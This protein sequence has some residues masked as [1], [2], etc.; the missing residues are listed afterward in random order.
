MVGD[1]E[2]V[3]GD[4][5]ILV[6]G[7]F[8]LVMLVKFCVGKSMI[9][10]LVRVFLIWWSNYCLCDGIVGCFFFLIYRFWWNGEY[11]FNF[12]KYSYLDMCL[13]NYVLKDV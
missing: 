2:W 9:I 3:I 12:V 1:F 11:F 13:R 5:I 10:I 8:W 4:L 7:I 6:K